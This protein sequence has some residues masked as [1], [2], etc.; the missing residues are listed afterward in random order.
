[1]PTTGRSPAA[2]N[3]NENSKQNYFNL[4]IVLGNQNKKHYASI[5]DVIK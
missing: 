4:V 1:M 2:T 5:T 3:R